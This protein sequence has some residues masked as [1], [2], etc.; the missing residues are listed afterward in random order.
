MQQMDWNTHNIV[1]D[2]LE[3]LKQLFPEAFSEDKVDFEKLQLLLWANITN[4]KEKY[5]FNWKGK[6][7]AIKLALAQNTWTLRP[8]KESSKNWD[9]TQNLYIEWD[10]LEVLRTLQ[11]SYRWQV[12]MIYIDPPYNTW[13]DF[14]YKD[15]F[16]DNVSSYKEKMWENMKSNPETN[17]RYH[18]DWLNMM[19]PRLKLAR[20]L[21]KND[22]VIFISIDDNEV[23]NL[24]KVCDEIF[25]EENFIWLMSI[26][27]NP[28]WRKNSN[29]LSIN[30]EF[31][32][33]YWKNIKNQESFFIESVMKKWLKIDENGRSYTHWKRVLVWEST[34]D[35]IEEWNKNY[36]VYYNVKNNILLKKAEKIDDIDNELISSWY[37]R[38]LS[39]RNW[40][41]IEN[42]YT[43]DKLYE[44]FNDNAL[45]F[46]DNSIYE[47]DFNVYSRAKTLLVNNDELDLKTETAWQKLFNDLWISFSFSKN[48][49]YLNFLIWLLNDNKWI[50]LDFFS[51]SATFAHAII[52]KNA[53]DWW[54]RK[55]IMIQIPEKIDE[56][57]WT[58]E[59]EKKTIRKTIDFLKKLWLELN[60][61]EIWKERIRRAWE[62]ILEENKDK[63]W[64]ENLDVWFK[65]FKLD[66]T[67]LKKWETSV[68]WETEDEIKKELQMRLQDMTNPVKDDR[69]QIDM[70]Y[71][72]MLKNGMDLSLPMHE[73][74][75]NWKK[76]FSIA[77][78]YLI[79]CLEKDINLETVKE[80]A[81]L[82]PKVAV[83]YDDSFADDRVK[84]NAIQNLEKNEIQVR[85]I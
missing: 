29:Y 84:I 66:T 41:L 55:F 48:V 59:P 13:K 78:N 25:W 38:F 80:I 68:E 52:Q 81:T 62:K 61:C 3:A 18:T 32:V 71:E 28:K 19:Y 16:H 47:K 30:N 14:V 82:N 24:R 51:W 69:N 42:T 26:E 72:I 63:E 10:N 60:I 53:I 40:R 33:V 73:L 2:N 5:S 64:I 36:V 57:N 43:F 8:D 35:F 83:F 70:V 31:C 65:V 85:V 12:K 76:V 67:N 1:N 17:G 37:K 23:H 45:I 22:W 75:I 39:S 46:K 21:L 56:N 54:S 74:S 4:D 79:A 50:Y 9:T 34:N 49:S 7:D 11:D 44:L 27:N 77:D 20:N 6:N 15:D 58:S